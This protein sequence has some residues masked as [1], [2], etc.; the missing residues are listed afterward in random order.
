MALKNGSA[1]LVP[2]FFP[3]VVK[4]KRTFLGTFTTAGDQLQFSLAPFSYEHSGSVVFQII[5]V[6]AGGTI[7][8]LTCDIQISLDGGVTFNAQVAAGAATVASNTAGINFQTGHVQSVALPGVGAE[9][10]LQFVVA[11]LA[12]GTATSV[13][14][15]ALMA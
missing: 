12:L 13:Q 7:T 8:T 9:A 15:W 4:G 11:T 1:G 6:A 14:V 2:N 3:V 10:V 5:P